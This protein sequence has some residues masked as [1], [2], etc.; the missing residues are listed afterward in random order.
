MKLWL[1]HMEI[2]FKMKRTD[3]KLVVNKLVGMDLFSEETDF[4]T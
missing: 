1:F 3:N 2:T 4:H